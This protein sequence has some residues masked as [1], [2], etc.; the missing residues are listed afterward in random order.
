VGLLFECACP[1]DEVLAWL[2]EDFVQCASMFLCMR[3]TMQSLIYVRGKWLISRFLSIIVLSVLVACGLIPNPGQPKMADLHAIT[4]YLLDGTLGKADLVPYLIAN[5]PAI[6]DAGFNTIYLPAVWADFDP[7]PMATPQ[8]YRATAFQNA[9]SALAAIRGAGMKALVGLNYIGVGFAPDFGTA[10]PAAQACDWA[11]TPSVYAAFERYV[12]AF[13]N[14]ML[15][16]RDIMSLMVFTEAAEG[17]GRGIQAAGPAVAF[18]LQKTL[19]SLPARLPPA[20]RAK[21]TLGYHDYSSVNLGWGNGVGPIALP[22]EFDFV[23]MVAYNV[24]TIAELDARAARFLALYPNK[25]LM[26]G[27]MGSNGCH[28]ETDQATT[29]ELLVDYALAHGHGFN[30]WGWVPGGGA[31]EAGMQECA[32]PNYGGLAI[33]NPDCSPRRAELAV[34]TLLKQ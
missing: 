29:D 12:A 11:I 22:N 8:T 34:K 4:V 13:M 5:L 3:V 28:N 30:L 9:Q 24:A 31:P 14:Q 33:T 27:E 17:C 23:S 1:L 16:N 6:K 18:Q 25:P 15:N 26:I 20:L 10:L 19:G 7:S 2:T 32:N 21:W